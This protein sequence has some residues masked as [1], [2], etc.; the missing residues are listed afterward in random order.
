[1]GGNA[2]ST[3][4]PNDPNIVYSPYNWKIGSAEA[5]TICGGAYLRVTFDGNPASVSAAF[6]VTNQPATG[7]SRV[8]FRI[9]DNAWQEA[10]VAATVTVAPPIVTAW[11]THTFEMVVIST[12]EAVSRWNAPQATAVQFLGL[13]GDVTL[14]TRATRKRDL[15]GLT[16]GDSITEGIRTKGIS[17]DPRQGIGYPLGDLLGAEIGVV[18]FAGT[19]ISDPGNADVP[20]FPDSLPY[21]WSGEPRNIATR[22]PD[23]VVGHVG[24]NDTPWSDAQVTADTTTL[25]NWLLANTPQ[26]CAIVI[27]PNWLQRKA[28]AI[29]AGI[30][31]SSSPSRVT[32]VDTTGWWNAA[33]SSDG[34]HPYGYAN[35]T[36]M[37]PRLATIVRA[38]IAARTAPAPAFYRKSGGSAVPVY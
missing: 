18:G 35:T 14:T 21:L 7:K 9:D 8:V 24:T 34:L 38:A 36:D 16:F 15:F 33:D 26:T 25:V 10:A 2:M 5:K 37:A 6:D 20:K 3:I 32:L 17:V 19:G 4:A 1:M 22:A 31:A 28:A 13:T 30:S 29:S 23:F 27:L 12:S 11:T